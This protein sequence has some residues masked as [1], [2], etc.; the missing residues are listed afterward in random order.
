MIKLC[1]SIAKLIENEFRRFSTISAGVTGHV[2]NEEIDLQGVAKRLTERGV[3]PYI[4]NQ[5]DRTQTG[6]SP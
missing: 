3:Q 2:V 5:E 4:D 1:S 6:T